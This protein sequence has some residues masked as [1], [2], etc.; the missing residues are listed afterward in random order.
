MP[1]K[2]EPAPAQPE[3]Q[4]P[5]AKQPDAPAKDLWEVALQQLPQSKQRK[6][7]SLGLDKLNSGAVESEIDDLIGVVNKKQEECEKKFWHVSVGEND[8]VL[9]NYTTKIVG[10]LEKAGDIAIQFAPPQASLPWSVVKSMM[11]VSNCQ[12]PP[13]VL[14]G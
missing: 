14:K 5:P 9:R 3:T 13:N 2:E 7:K 12:L 11:K 8:F 4:P 10:W 6:L 1:A